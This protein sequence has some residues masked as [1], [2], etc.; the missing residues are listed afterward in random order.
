METEL[1]EYCN[2]N[3]AGDTE[4][5]Q[6]TG[7]YIM[8]LGDGV[9]SW[10]LQKQSTIALSSTKSE[11]MALTEISHEIIWMWNLLKQLRLIIPDPTI[12]YEDNQGMMAF[13]VNQK[14]LCRMKYI[15]VKYHYIQELIKWSVIK[16]KYKNTKEMVAN[17]LTKSLSQVAHK[18]LTMKL[19]LVPSALKEECCDSS[20]EEY[21]CEWWNKGI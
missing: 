5:W 2:A 20:T 10:A 1:Y 11:Y 14:A 8:L 13:A 21:K 7:G 15:E 9:I 6:S 19:G 16:L 4:D 12:A 18:Y 17:I 3:F